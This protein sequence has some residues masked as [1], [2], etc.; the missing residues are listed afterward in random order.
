MADTFGALELPVDGAIDPVGDPG[1][2]KLGSFLQAVI[3]DKLGTA[4]AALRPR[5]GDLALPVRTIR[6]HNPRKRAF[7]D[8]D[9][10]A[11]FIYRTKDAFQRDAEDYDQDHATLIVEWIYP[12]DTQAKG[13]TRSSVGNAVGKIVRRALEVAVSPAWY[14]AGDTTETARSFDADPDSIALARPTSLAP[15]TLSGAQLDGAIGG[16][17]MAPR[18]EVRI[19]TSAVLVPTYNTSLPIVITGVNWN[20]RTRTWR[21]QLTNP[22]GGESIGTNEEIAS[23]TSRAAPAM[24]AAG[25]S[26]ELGTSA[27]VGLGSDLLERGGFSR[28]KLLTA[29]PGQCPID[30]ID[31]KG[32]KVDQ[33]LYD[34]VEMALDVIERFDGDPSADPN[35][36]EI[37]DEDPTGPGLDLDLLESDGDGVFESAAF[38]VIPDL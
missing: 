24:L 28:C 35:V 18:R 23:V 3:N 17:T 30:V 21:I 33:L 9:L 6:W 25:G 14:D 26:I 20:G 1:L 32:K 15:E 27:V 2:S 4:W 36:G 8:K 19:T 7:S 38:P 11:L 13:K 29:T 10:P 31:G 16:A 37:D 12:P 22:L 5:T 34:T